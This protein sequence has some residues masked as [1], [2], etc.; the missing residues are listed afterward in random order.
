MLRHHTA[1]CT[2]SLE[3]AGP[4]FRLVVTAPYSLFLCIQSYLKLARSRADMLH[5]Q[6]MVDLRLLLDLLLLD[7]LQ[8]PFVGA[9]EP[10]RGQNGEPEAKPAQ[11]S[12]Q[13]A[14]SRLFRQC[15]AFQRCW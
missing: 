11:P 4:S 6:F 2:Q 5:Q 14:R 12:A 13:H 7:L 9:L 15:V 1:G 3:I 10:G 8:A